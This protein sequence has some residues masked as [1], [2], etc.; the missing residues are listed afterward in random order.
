M[1]NETIQIDQSH[2]P[3]QQQVHS[4]VE[5]MKRAYLWD[6]PMDSEND[7]RAVERM[8]VTMPVTLTPLDDEFRPLG[9]QFEAI[10]RDLSCAGIGMMT[11]NPLGKYR[12]LLTLRPY[13]GEPFNVMAEISYCNDHGYYFQV[14]CKFLTA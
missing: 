5:N 8:I 12:V 1:N 4:F 10:S 9:Y 3:T 6:G 2:Q 13:Q 11:T 14:G 7:R